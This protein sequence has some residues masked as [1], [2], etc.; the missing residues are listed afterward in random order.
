MTRNLLPGHFWTW[1]YHKNLIFRR[2]S[3]VCRKQNFR[4]ISFRILTGRHFGSKGST[5]FALTCICEWNY[6][7]GLNH[8]MAV[9][10]FTMPCTARLYGSEVSPT[11]NYKKKKSLA[12]ISSKSV[13]GFCF[14][15][16]YF[17]TYLCLNEEKKHTLFQLPK[18]FAL[19]F[20]VL[21]FIIYIF[22]FNSES[23][24]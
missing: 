12:F 5:T 9:R 10:L 7:E 19:H 13:S 24:T 8:K 22:C 21:F 23:Y 16:V 20:T 3:F 17:I 18:K 14:D 11:W 2:A 1:K 4:W 15:S 6:T